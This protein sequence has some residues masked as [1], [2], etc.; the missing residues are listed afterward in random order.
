MGPWTKEQAPHRSKHAV[1]A[2]GTAL[3]PQALISRVCAFAP[4]RPTVV[5]FDSPAFWRAIIPSIPKNG[6]GNGF[7][8]VENT[9]LKAITGILLRRRSQKSATSDTLKSMVAFLFHLNGKE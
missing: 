3:K 9:D 6:Q 4:L 1:K 8:L 2:Q 7:G 5:C